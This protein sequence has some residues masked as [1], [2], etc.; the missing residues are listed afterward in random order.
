M[1]AFAAKCLV[2]S[3]FLFGFPSSTVFAV[4]GSSILSELEFTVPADDS[5]RVQS[6]D[7][8]FDGY[9]SHW[10]SHC[11]SWQFCNGLFHASRTEPVTEFGRLK[12]DIGNG[13]LLDELWIQ[14]GFIS[15]LAER[16][17]QVFDLRCARNWRRD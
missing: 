3:A 13:L 6:R 4:E 14:R 16:R 2:F 9:T 12:D 7:D 10:E 11:W 17:P 5:S 15:R 8:R 1:N